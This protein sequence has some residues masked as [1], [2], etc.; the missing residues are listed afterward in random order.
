MKVGIVA[1]SPVPFVLGGAENLWSG[2]L[3]AFN[4]T[5]GIEADLIKIPSPER[6]F[7]EIVDSYR[8][9]SALALDH[10]DLLVSTKYPAWM[11]SHPNHVVLLQH[12]LRGLYDVWPR[13][14][15][16]ELDGAWPLP[17]RLRRV[18]GRRPK[19]HAAL[20]EIFG[21]LDELRARVAEC[22]HEMFALPGALIRSI[23]HLLDGIGL[24]PD[25]IRRYLAISAT[26]AA[27]DD[28]FPEGV[29]VEVLHHAT[30]LQTHRGKAQRAIFTASRLEAPKRVGLLIEAYQR[31]RVSLPLRIAGEGSELARL[32]EL[33]HGVPGIEF[34]GRIT[35]RALADEYADALVVAF[36]PQL[37]D[38]GLI[39]LEAMQSGKPVLTVS[40]AGGVAELVRDGESG[41]I[42][43]PTPD[44]LAEALRAFCADRAEAARM[45]EA[46][47]ASVHDISWERTVERLL[48]S[49]VVRASVRPRLV[50]ANT[51]GVHPPTSGGQERIFHLYR[52][53]TDAFDVDLVAVDGRTDR[54]A[55]R[56]LR[57]GFREWVVPKTEEFHVLEAEVA[58]DTGVSAEDVV[59]AAYREV[60]PEFAERLRE[61]M[62]DAAIVVAAHPY[63]H[64]AIR[65]GWSGPLVYDAHNV[66]WDLKRSIFR[67]GSRWADFVRDVEG[68][69]TRDAD[70][71]LACSPEDAWC[72]RA[73]YRVDKS[74]LEIIANGCDLE[75]LHWV[76]PERRRALK[77]RLGLG[78]DP[79]CLFIGSNHAPNVDAARHVIDL[80]RTAPQARFTVVGSVCDALRDDPLPGNVILAGRV[81]DAE[82]TVWLAAADIGLNPIVAGSG[83]NLKVVAY[84]AL[85]M[86]ILSTRLGLRGDVLEPWE[87]A[88]VAE[89]PEMPRVLAEMLVA[90]ELCAERAFKARERVEAVADWRV[91]SGRLRTRLAALEP[92]RQRSASRVATA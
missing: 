22:P 14:L 44:A 57:P 31:A 78:N 27:R 32:R 84:A 29:N 46:A 67:P 50:I 79:C 53:L 33:A 82:K 37:E 90:P 88:W 47:A 92:G 70:L 21:A 12:K 64:P 36:V 75:A 30:N 6:N 41:R 4:A 66:E 85:G 86:A 5:P 24:A 23:V 16:T 60:V 13:G 10:F 89:I 83:T 34:L 74:R 42:V 35:D 71:V 63:A 11:V 59:T 56:E 39:A 20:P 3:G 17:V 43:A 7:W 26:V 81:S 48:V 62:R 45:G 80:A 1:P 77:Q 9:F 68:T 40:D 15:A 91:L 25:A 61:R 73:L 8:R 54:P 69:C 72:L 19:S 2:L 38:Y 18:L 76:S 58:R 49:P 55:V 52:H 51:F 65:D 28:Y 87:H